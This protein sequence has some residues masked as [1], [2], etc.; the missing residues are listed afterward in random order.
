VAVLGGGPSLDREA[1]EAARRRCGR[2]VAVN[3][4][5]LLAPWAD[6]VW[7]CDRRWWDWH[8]ARP[9]WLAFQGSK[10]TLENLALRRFEPGLLCFRND[11]V[12]GLCLRPD[13][14]RTGSSGGYQAVNL[15]ANMGAARILLFGFDMRRVGGRANWHD[16]HRVKMPDSVFARMIERFATLVAPLREAGIEIVNCTPGSA[17]DCFPFDVETT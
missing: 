12:S 6:L 7:F 1:V 17:L 4:A 8:R 5:Y 14:V 10:A 3:N 15:A 9:E 2:V 11:G 13:G 16:D